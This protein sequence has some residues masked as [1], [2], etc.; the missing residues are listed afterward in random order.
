MSTPCS[1]GLSTPSNIGL[2]APCYSSLPAL[3][4]VTPPD[5]LFF[6]SPNNPTGAAA[7]RAQLTQLV[8]FAL[9]SG[10]IIVYDAAYSLFIR[11]PDCPRT[12]YEIPGAEY[13]AMETCSF[14]KY[15]GFT[16]ARLGWTVV[17]PQLKFVGGERVLDS[18]TRIMTTIFNGR[19]A[20]AL[21]WGVRYVC[22]HQIGVNH[23]ELS[24]RKAHLT[25]LCV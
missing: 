3:P 2:S 15:A 5:V 8:E 14:S 13:C 9:K 6:C 7:T 25:S 11:N 24:S 12:I 16:G 19:W 4:K 10:C 18:W 21:G 20:A 22:A 1:I 23:V 17:P